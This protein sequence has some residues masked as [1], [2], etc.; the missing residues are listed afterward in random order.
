MSIF[1][2]GDVFSPNYQ[3]LEQYCVS[4][5]LV[6]FISVS[7]N[8]LVQ[9]CGTILYSWFC[10]VLGFRD[11]HLLTKWKCDNV[12]GVNSSERAVRKVKEE[13]FLN[14]LVNLHSIPM[15]LFL[16]ILRVAIVTIC[17]VSKLK[18]SI[19]DFIVEL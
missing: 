14:F 15:N 9:L 5:R 16:K 12:D 18:A 17:T 7:I 10:P 4:T 11:I 13:L 6:I 19:C 3:S 2:S 1:I 8:I